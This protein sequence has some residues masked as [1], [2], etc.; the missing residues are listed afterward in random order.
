[1]LFCINI[2]K[3]KKA[4]RVKTLYQFNK[5]RHDDLE[6]S[7]NEVII[8][9]PFQDE[10]SEWWYGTNEDTNESGYFPK[11]YVEKIDPGK[12]CYIEKKIMQILKGNKI[13]TTTNTCQCT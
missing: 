6:F 9:Q 10:N 7:E 13:S 2:Y 11:T 4:F 1:L 8:V 5:T 12:R 3:Y